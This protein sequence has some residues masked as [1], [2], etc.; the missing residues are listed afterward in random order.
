MTYSEGAARRP[1]ILRPGNDYRRLASERR[2]DPRVEVP[3][4]DA[5]G[6]IDREGDLLLVLD[7]SARAAWGRPSL[8]TGYLL[9]PGG[10]AG[11]DRAFSA[12]LT[13]GLQ[14]E[15]QGSGVLTLSNSEGGRASLIK[16]RA[17][18]VAKLLDSM[19]FE[20]PPA[21][22]RPNRLATLPDSP[23]WPRGAYLY[24]DRSP[25]W[26]PEDE[27][28]MI[29][30]PGEMIE[31]EVIGDRYLRSE[32][33]QGTFVYPDPTWLPYR[34][35][36][37]D[38]APAIEIPRGNV[39]ASPEVV[40]LLGVRERLAPPH[41]PDLGT[42]SPERADAFA[43]TGHLREVHANSLFQ[44]GDHALD[45]LTSKTVKP[46]KDETGET[47]GE[48]VVLQWE[49]RKYGR[50][51]FSL[52]DSGLYA[53]IPS[54]DGDRNERLEV[55]RYGVLITADRT[56]AETLFAAIRDLPE[57]SSGADLRDLLRTI[58]GR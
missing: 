10:R 17:D 34:F 14:A 45:T 13:E 25:E 18:E 38:G 15:Y 57:G 1:A 4:K 28:L 11:T 44:G 35:E 29:G 47:F 39:G 43:A 55:G 24:G 37:A 3:G 19:T 36:P 40:D 50:S 41:V 8:G 12:S 54:L 42:V 30:T 26:P 51:A 46:L 22:F 52:L 56:T 31:W 58:A 32:T 33:P 16:A 23:Y 7:G 5:A 49:D 53:W 2:P 9:P 48:Q 21:L 20:V 27:R 6:F